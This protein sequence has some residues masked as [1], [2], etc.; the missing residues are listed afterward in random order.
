MRHQ[1][2]FFRGPFD[3]EV[4]RVPREWAYLIRPLRG[5]FAQCTGLPSSMTP[6]GA[7]QYVK[8]ST[9]GLYQL[10]KDAPQGKPRMVWLEGA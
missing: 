1:L 10:V 9:A 2:E 4:H 8:S 3:G 7:R 5:G 6:E